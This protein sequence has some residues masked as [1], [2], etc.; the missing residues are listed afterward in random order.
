MEVDIYI[1]EADGSRELR[2]PWL[3]D[4]IKFTSN[5]TR[6][7]S[8]EI[9]DVGEV[10]VPTGSNLSGFSWSSIFPGEGHK[11]LPFLRGSW[12]SPKN[13]QTL[14]SEWREYGTPLR[15]IVTGTPINHDVY[16]AD[17]DVAYE[18]GYGDYKYD[19]SFI[20]R[21]R[22]KITSKKVASS[23]KSSGSSGSGGGKTYTVKS[24]DTLWAIAQKYYGAGSK[25][26][27]IYN[28]N[29]SIIES[30]AK[31]RGFNSSNGGHWIFPGQ[32]LQI[33]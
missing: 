28:A 10:Q 21:R 18:S 27:S 7:A 1:K 32:V 3:P 9:L 6:M 15:L 11:D 20:R 2:I 19:I 14:L 22:I 29:Q 13:I 26:G 33:P 5:G 31:S 23:G 30:T 25:Y 16:L 17:Y 4:S 12:K 8:Y 24:G